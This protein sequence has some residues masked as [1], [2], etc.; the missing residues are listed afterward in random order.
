MKLIR[1]RR[2][3][4]DILRPE[5]SKT[6]QHLCKHLTT[7]ALDFYTGRD[8]DEHLRLLLL[9]LHAHHYDSRVCITTALQKYLRNTKAHLMRQLRQ[10]R[11]DH[12][13]RL[14]GEY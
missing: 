8:T 9:A 5:R 2:H 13:D 14:C 3:I 6:V 1:L 12:V 11:A 7:N 4:I 10:D